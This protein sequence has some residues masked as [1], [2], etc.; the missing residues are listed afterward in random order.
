MKFSHKLRQCRTGADL[1][2]AVMQLAALLAG[3]YLLVIPGYPALLTHR[4]ALSGVFTLGMSALPRWEAAALSLLYRLTASEVAVFFGMVGGALAFG[5]AAGRLLTGERTA[6]TVRVILAALIAAD[7]ALR[8]LPLRWNTLFPLPYAIAGF[9]LR[10]GCLALV[11][12]DLR[13]SSKTD[14]ST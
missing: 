10:L 3:L 14:A 2:V 13:V 4:S 7:L 8:L 12:R 1:Y 9:V 6:R 5:L 11:L